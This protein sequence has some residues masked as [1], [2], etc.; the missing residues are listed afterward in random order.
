MNRVPQGLAQFVSAFLLLVGGGL[1]A[2]VYVNQPVVNL[3]GAQD[4]NSETVSQAIYGAP[5]NVL[6]KDGDFWRVQTNDG[7]QGWIDPQA[8]I[9]KESV[10]PDNSIPNAAVKQLWAYVYQVEDTTPHPPKIALPFETRVEVLSP[11]DKWNERWIQ[12]KLVDDST[13]YM[14]KGDL[15][16][17]PK[18]LSLDEMLSL[19]KKFLGLPY[20][21]GGTSGFGFDC[22]GFVQMLFRQAGVN[23]PRDSKDQINYEGGTAVAKEDIQP[24][25]LVFFKSLSSGKIVHVGLAIDK[26]QF[27]HTTVKGEPVLQISRLDEF[28]GYSSYGFGG[29]RRISIP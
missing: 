16:F 15:S 23:L 22:S 1:D 20:R 4:T 7:Y 26:D 29:A 21:W 9:E 3:L 13:G 27:I 28:L 19:S 6:L 17:E 10:F 14:Q 8:L 12:V 5:I 2:V 25:D 24:G 11:K 18:T